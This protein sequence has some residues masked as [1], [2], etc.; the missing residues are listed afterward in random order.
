MVHETVV[1]NGGKRGM[2]VV[3]APQDAVQATAGMVAPLIAES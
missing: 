2:M 1:I 3:L